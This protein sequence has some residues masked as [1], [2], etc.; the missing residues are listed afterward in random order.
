MPDNKL[1]RLGDF[2]GTAYQQPLSQP[3]ERVTLPRIGEIVPA[4]QPYTPPATVEETGTWG[5][6]VSTIAPVLDYLSRGQY[7]SAKFFDSLGDESKTFLDKISEAA[8]EIYD[9]KYRLSFSDV[10]KRNAPVWSRNNPNS[11]AVLGFLGDVF[12]DPTTYLGVGFG[13]N[14]IKVGGKVLTSLGRETLSNEAKVV[15]QQLG[16]KFIDEEVRNTAEKNILGLLNNQVLFES[17]RA[18]LTFFGKNV[19]GS[20][21]ILNATGL[22]KL[23][24]GVSSIGET[25]KRLDRE[26]I[27]SRAMKIDPS[28]SQKIGESLGTIAGTFNRDFNLPEEWLNLRKHLENRKDAI[29][30]EVEREAIKLFGRIETPRRQNIGRAMSTIDD[31]T[32]MIEESAK[33]LGRS[34]TQQEYDYIVQRNLARYGIDK[35]PEE[36]A[37]VANLYQQYK[38]AGELEVQAGLL[39]NLIE[40]Y[41]PRKYLALANPGEIP[42]YQKGIR[43]LSTNLSSSKQRDFLTLAEAESKGYIPELDAAM[44]YASRMVESRQKLANL[45]FRDAIRDT[46]GFENFNTMPARFKNDVKLIGESIYP[47]QLN[48]DAGNI[49]KAFDFLQTKFKQAATVVKPSFA[50]KQLV[51]NTFQSAMLS[52]LKAFKTLDPRSAVDAGLLLLDRGKPTKS[53]PKFLDNL[54]SRYSGEAGVDAVL[55]QR[56]ALSK[57]TGEERLKDYAKDFKLINV[58]GQNYTGDELVELARNNGVIRGFDVTGERFQRRV[59]EALDY[60][61]NS[62]KDVFWQGMKYWHHAQLIEDYSRMTM[63]INGV[64]MGYRPEQ[65]AQLVNKALFDYSRGLSSMERDVFRR[66]LPFYT[67]QRFAI[68]YTF[69][70]AATKAG[71]PLTAD[72]LLKLTDKLF[73]NG[74]TLTEDERTIFGNTFLV[75]QPRFFSGMDKDGNATFNVF[76]NLTPLDSLDFL[77]VDKNGKIDYQR[78]AEQTILAAL[79]PFI[80]VPVEL[81]ENKN[82]FSGRTLQDAGRLGDVNRVPLSDAIGSVIPSFV[83][84]AIGWENRVDPKTGK[85][86]SYINPYIAHIAGSFIPAIKTFIRPLSPENSPLDGAMELL[87]G[88][89]SRTLDFKQ[90]SEYQYFDLNKQAQ[91]IKHRMRSAMYKGSES[92]YSRAKADY[93]ELIRDFAKTSK[94]IRGVQENP[95]PQTQGTI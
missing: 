92:E 54:I 31:E 16:K 23:A 42:F 6:V 77:K 4:P 12:L 41:S 69:K 21:T 48:T 20:E 45:Q 17:G 88:F 68:P 80:K 83:K 82:F 85:T 7:A 87:T 51:S 95:R 38:N 34:I 90:Q 50:A 63:F 33:S 35:N 14:G 89:G 73:N 52:G 30:D 78:T 47:D 44:L 67:F 74:E 37:V 24:E 46:F 61:P 1:P 79:T 13:K 32:R 58:F 2:A 57:I 62:V 81:A 65:S 84:E 39:N 86:T 26:A 72:K 27:A 8:M 60:N 91:E 25:I 49:L 66:V 43:G 11:T 70:Q 76:N 40:N 29:A 9:P 22:N 10:I 28:I 36:M 55:A 19:P 64:R 18:R 5:A 71:I 75:E 94:A 56:T 3:V 59:A 15:A 93:E 53:L